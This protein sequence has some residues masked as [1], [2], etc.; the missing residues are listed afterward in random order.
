DTLGVTNQDIAYHT[1]CVRAGSRELFV[2][3][4]MPFM[5]YSSPNDT[6]KNAA[7][8]MRAGAN[9]VKLE[10]GEWLFESIEALTQ[11]GIPVCG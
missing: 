8:L 9:M 1:R 10:G 3:A 7:E 11:Q 2:I 6:C 4:D 5:T